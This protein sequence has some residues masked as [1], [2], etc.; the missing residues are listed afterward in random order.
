MAT[1]NRKRRKKREKLAF[2]AEKS[3]RS[4]AVRGEARAGC[5]TGSASGSKF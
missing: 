3:H 1:I 4:A 5:A 2:K